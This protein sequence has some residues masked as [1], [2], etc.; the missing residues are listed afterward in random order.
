MASSGQGLKW[1]LTATIILAFSVIVLGGYWLLKGGDE[2]PPPK[3]LPRMANLPPETENKLPPPPSY[4]PDAPVLDQVRKALSDGITPADAVVMARTLPDRPER[5]DAAFLL[6]EYAAESGNAEAALAVGR[7]YDPSDP[8]ASGTIRKNP[9]TAYEWYMKALAGG[10][11][12]A[13]TKLSQLRGWVEAKAT[14]G[15]KDAQALLNNWR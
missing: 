6:L 9:T 1:V 12:K 2:A 8:G 15:S 14:Q 4:P 13:Q 10:E 7:F 5:A 3:G 11:S